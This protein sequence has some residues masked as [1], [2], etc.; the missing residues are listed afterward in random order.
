MKLLKRKYSRKINT[1]DIE[2]R[3]MACNELL[4]QTGSIGREVKLS[5]RKHSGKINPCDMKIIKQNMCI[6]NILV[7]TANHD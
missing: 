4:V 7:N 6:Y 2:I 5:Q 1:C 3:K